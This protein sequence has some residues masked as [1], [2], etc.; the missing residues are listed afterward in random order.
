LPGQ[1]GFLPVGEAF[2]DPVFGSTIR[3]LTAQSPQS[4]AGDTYARNGWWN[5]DSTRV[6]WHPSAG[7]C[8][9]LDAVSGG[10]VRSGVPCQT[11]SGE[12]SFAP[13]DPRLLYYWSGA[14][15]RT[16][17][18]NDG[19]TALVKTFPATVENLGGSV[20]YVDRTGRYFVLRYGGQ[21]RV[22]DK[23][24]DVVYAGGI[25]RDA[26]G[27]WT[28][29]TPNAS[30]VVIATGGGFYSYSINHGGRAIGPETLFW[31]LCGDHSDLVSGS[32]GKS[33]LVGIECSSEDAVYR[34]DVSLLQSPSP[35]G[36]A[37]QRASNLK[38]IHLGS[39][40]DASHYS[41][42][43][44]SDWCVVSFEA[45]DDDFLSM[46]Q[47]R[48]YKSELVAVNVIS[49]EIRRLAHHRSRGIDMGYYN[50]PHPS[51]SWD[52]SRL[53]WT[54]NFGLNVGGLGYGDLYSMDMPGG[55]A[56]SGDTTPPS[57]S[58]TAPANG[59]T[60][61]GTTSVSA[62]ASDN[63]GVVGVQFL[64][65]GTNVGGEDTTSPYSLSWNSTTVPNG[66]H[67]ISA[68][69]RDA[70]GNVA[71]AAAVTVNV[72]NGTAGDTSPPSVSMT[73]PSN[74]ATVSSTITVSANATDNVGVVGVQFLLD[75]ANLGSEDSS[76]PFSVSWNTTSVS[77]GTHTL[78]AR[79]RDAAG[80][81]T[82]ASAITVDVNNQTSGDTTPPNISMTSPANGATVS[83]NVVVSA[84]ATDNVAVTGVQF[85]LNGANL[86][87]EVLASPYSLL[88]NSAGV[89]AGS[90]VLS[91]TAR[92]AAGNTRTS[93]TVT[94]MVQNAEAGTDTTPP[95][96]TITSPQN[97]STVSGSVVFAADASDNVGVS[98]VQFLLNGSPVGT[99][100]LAPPYTMTWN[101][102]TASGTHVLSAIAKDAAGNT[103]TAAGSSF[104]IKRSS[105]DA[106]PRGSLERVSWTDLVNS[107]LYLWRLRK[108][109][110]CDDC[111]DAGAR[112]MQRLAS[113]DGYVE[114][115]AS[116][117]EKVY[118]VGFGPDTPGTSP[119]DLD[120]GL[121]VNGLRA[122][123][124]EANAP[125]ATEPI[126]DGDTLR[127]SINGGI[128]TYS[129][130]GTVFY[131]SQRQPIFPLAV[132]AVLMDRRAEVSRAY[133]WRPP[134]AT[135]AAATGSTT[136]IQSGSGASSRD[137]TST[138]PKAAPSSGAAVSRQPRTPDD[139]PLP[140]RRL[141]EFD[142]TQTDVSMVAEWALSLA[143]EAQANVK[144]VYLYAD[145][146]TESA[147]ALF[148]GAV[149]PESV[150]ESAEESRLA[151]ERIR[152][153]LAK[154]PTGSFTIAAFAQTP[155]GAPYELGTITVVIR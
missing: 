102:N 144:A 1:P 64:V 123:V 142:R 153:A 113:G 92:D 118:Y 51:I 141:L 145:P 13:D 147:D 79:A 41:C 84:N 26:G 37:A 108:T 122:D 9:V 112:S 20:D 3:R 152:R 139:E 36:A 52:G 18:I 130:N 53:M 132:R 89:P 96:V 58:V 143:A 33:Y 94:V 14:S 47:W 23:Q 40:R 25:S 99:P 50:Q 146:G 75:G 114:F 12:V 73:A 70:A 65:D 91:A 27:G 46:G 62:N 127:L 24:S 150:G 42:S 22:W 61:T 34:V 104:G 121:R 154:F 30:H 78:T 59:A 110:G 10:V 100:L 17:N 116:K 8:L 83:G 151:R 60:V 56:P 48:P 95:N 126:R 90:H 115:T 149:S 44:R 128:V 137:T 38:L 49:G 66:S 86:G 7:G 32:D 135:S 67:T 11:A 109:E 107:S 45:I 140:R 43:S 39:W 21:T 19:S 133:L 125:K 134:V 82:M 136:G 57:V 71:T 76:S 106:A 5:S 74:G 120:Y 54:S 15:L 93:A 4:G 85:R 77:N 97:G 81:T 72:S 111:A 117:S 101:T 131:T 6:H 155:S 35:G 87:L 138:A 148:L 98:S 55:G 69:A 29:I 129:R 80:N 105:T 88:W 124:Y 63:V 2:V 28:G 103:R 31:D 16:F 119:Q 68:R